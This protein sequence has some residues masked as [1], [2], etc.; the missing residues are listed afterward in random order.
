MPN[1]ADALYPGGPSTKLGNET[2][3][4]A[5][6]KNPDL[7][8]HLDDVI[9]SVAS[10]LSEGERDSLKTALMKRFKE[11]SFLDAFI[12]GGKDFGEDW[13][14]MISGRMEGTSFKHRKKLWE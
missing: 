4:E 3:E 10:K 13:K 11:P 14:N 9:G 12:A 7:G 5:A 8:T 6:E 2:E 1:A